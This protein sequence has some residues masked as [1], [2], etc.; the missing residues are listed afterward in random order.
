MPHSSSRSGNHSLM[1]SATTHAPHHIPTQGRS[2]QTVARARP[3]LLFHAVG[4]SA[5][6]TRV[7]SANTT[8]CPDSSF[9]SSLAN[10]SSAAGHA[11]EC[12]MDRLGCSGP[13][14]V[15]WELLDF[16]LAVIRLWRYPGAG[17]AYGDLYAFP[18]R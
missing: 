4:T 8:V 10:R 7:R 6:L 9:L 16:Q 13:A 18:A 5:Q 15:G 14:T 17:D 3:W 1:L 2:V 12:D 11:H